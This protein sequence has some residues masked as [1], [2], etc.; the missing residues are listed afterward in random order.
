MTDNPRLSTGRR[1]AQLTLAAA[2][3]LYG[4]IGFPG[5][6]GTSTN[7]AVAQG[8]DAQCWAILSYLSD[9]GLDQEQIENLGNSGLEPDPDTP[10]IVP[11]DNGGYVIVR[12]PPDTFRTLMDNS[13][14]DQW[15]TSGRPV[16]TRVRPKWLPV[17]KVGYQG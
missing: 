17:A 3:L 14:C 11:G 7:Y 1:W 8:C 15:S 4:V 2:V 12:P 6:P 9:Q 10:V 13:E 16:A 5:V